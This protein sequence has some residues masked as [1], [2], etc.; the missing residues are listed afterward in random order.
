M[1]QRAQRISPYK[2][3][4]TTR[5]P[6]QPRHSRRTGAKRRQ[7]ALTSRIRSQDRGDEECA[8]RKT[9][10][11]LVSVNPFLFISLLPSELLSS[12]KS[13]CKVLFSLG[14]H[15][16]HERKG[17]GA[18]LARWGFPRADAEGLPCYVDASD[19][20]YP[21]YRRLGFEDVGDMTLDLDGFEGGKGFGVQRWV[22]MVREHRK[23]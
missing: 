17:A 16:S 8:C 18:Q 13:T 21:L 10:G 23:V 6:F 7:R 11:A 4:L 3:I 9:R 19:L 2:P 20:G 5:T 15:P 12:E 22:A 14:T 1:V